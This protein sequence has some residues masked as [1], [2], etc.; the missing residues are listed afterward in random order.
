VSEIQQTLDVPEPQV[1]DIPQTVPMPPG[2]VEA[3]MY[4]NRIWM[5]ES[6]TIELPGGLTGYYMTPEGACMNASVATVL[7]RPLESIPDLREP[8]AIIF[9]G[10]AE[11]IDVRYLQPRVDPCPEGL[12]LGVTYPLPNGVIPNQRHVLV[13]KDGRLFFDPAGCFLWP[14]GKQA[15]PIVGSEI[16]YAI[17]LTPKEPA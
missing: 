2:Y 5:R 11:G 10:E 7:Q 17:T 14:N 1:F 15:P 6:P 8:A 13:L 3:N 4:G 16:E 9:W 12:A